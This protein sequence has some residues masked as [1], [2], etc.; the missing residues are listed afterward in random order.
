MSL[1]NQILKS[2]I[3]AIYTYIGAEGDLAN[4]SLRHAWLAGLASPNRSA[5]R[6][7][8]SCWRDGHA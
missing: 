1:M 4:V 5:A 6:P 7:G 8:T 3:V 2:M